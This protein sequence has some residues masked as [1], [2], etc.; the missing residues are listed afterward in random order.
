MK[1]T[2]ALVLLILSF[3]IISCNKKPESKAL[4]KLTDD[5]FV[6]KTAE[7]VV[8]VDFWATWCAPCRAL[9]PTISAIA[10]ESNGKYRVGKVD[11]DENPVTAM[12]YGIRS[13]PTIIIFV[14][15]KEAERFVGLQS[16]SALESA[17]AKYI[18]K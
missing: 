11:V 1:S 13:I 9:A 8:L 10:D 5:S 7:G 17:L 6:A 16:K 15:G 14:N 2:L 3:T 4:I 18:Q 12:K